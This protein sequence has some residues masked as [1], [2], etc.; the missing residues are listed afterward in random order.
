MEMGESGRAQRDAHL[1]RKYAAKMGHPE[2]RG[3]VVVLPGKD[4]TILFDE[5][6]WLPLIAGC[7]CVDAIFS[8]RGL[9]H[10][11]PFKMGNH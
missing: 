7:F 6:A 9:K 3:T 10:V 11:R 5:D 2:C 4:A 8:G 1:S